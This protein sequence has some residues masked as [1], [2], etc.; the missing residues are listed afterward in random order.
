[1]PGERITEKKLGIIR[2]RAAAGEAHDSLEGIQQLA[3]DAGIAWTF[4]R[5]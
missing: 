4:W 2:Q 5:Q 1:M 3:A